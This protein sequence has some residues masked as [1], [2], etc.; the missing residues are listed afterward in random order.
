MEIPTIIDIGSYQFKNYQLLDDNEQKIAL[1]FRNKNREW[2]INKKI[3]KIE[4]HKNWINSLGH[5]ASTIYYLVFKKNIPFMSVDF[6]DID[7][8]KKEA[9]WGYFLGEQNYKTEVLRIEK[10]IIDIAFSNL[11]LDKLICIND[12]DNHVIKIHKFFGFME[13]KIIK[14][15]GKEFLRMYLLKNKS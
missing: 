14:I 13:D 9:Y 12:I 7:F 1:G 10:I 4:E 8:I 6:H 5:D 11:N 3:I 2:M 15:N